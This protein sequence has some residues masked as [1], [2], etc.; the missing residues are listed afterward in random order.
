MPTIEEDP[1]RS[2]VSEPVI[3]ATP[4]SE[5]EGKVINA[6]A[7]IVA[8][9][10]R[11]ALLRNSSLPVAVNE[12]TPVIPDEPKITLLPV[13]RTSPDPTNSEVG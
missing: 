10:T 1:I 3:E 5:A 2:V 13:P 9:L 11:P 6:T 7:F 4:V 8:T 12:A